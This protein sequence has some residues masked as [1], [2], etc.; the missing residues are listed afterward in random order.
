MSVLDLSKLGVFERVF[1]GLFSKLGV[2]IP[3][4]IN[5]SVLEKAKTSNIT[6]ELNFNEKIISKVRK[7]QADFY[8]VTVTKEIEERG[9]CLR[10]FSKNDKFKLIYFTNDGNVISC[11]D[12]YK[13]K[14]ESGFRASFYFLNFLGINV[15]NR[16]SFLF[17]F[18][19]IFI[20]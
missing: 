11:E 12:A 7:Q 17:F 18:F 5:V 3:T 19:L 16:F 6:R 1:V 9:M 4:S 20:N 2:D 13:R 8:K 15:S 10:V 14:G